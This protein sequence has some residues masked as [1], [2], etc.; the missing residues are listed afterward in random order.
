MPQIPDRKD[1]GPIRVNGSANPAEINPAVAYDIGRAGTAMEAA[2]H[3]V[4]ASFAGLGE[5]QAAMEDA[6]WLSDAKIKTMEA[7]D[8]IRRQTELNA[9]PNGSGYAQ[10]APTLQSSVGEIEKKAG[11]SAKARAEFKLWSAG[12]VYKTGAW[13]ANTA[14]GKAS[15]SEKATGVHPSGCQATVAASIPEQTLR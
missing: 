10:A 8:A 2:M 9:E 15:I 7:D 13:G 12:E 4:A 14:Q 5:K 1:L 3:Q 6:T 11:G